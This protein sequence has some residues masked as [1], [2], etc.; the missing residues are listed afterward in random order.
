MKL[1]KIGTCVYHSRHGKNPCLR[2]SIEE[3]EGKSR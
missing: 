2:I 3:R 1:L